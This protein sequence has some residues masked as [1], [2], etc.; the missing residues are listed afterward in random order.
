ML[1]ILGSFSLVIALLGFVPGETATAVPP[2]TRTVSVTG[3]GES[4]YP[5]FSP[6]V[7][8]YGV[9][10]TAEASP[11][12]GR[13]TVRATTSDPTGTVLVNGRPSTGGGVTVTGLSAG[14]EISVII[15]DS[16]GTEVHALVYLPAGFPHLTTVVDQPGTAAGDVMLTLSKWVSPAPSYEVAVDRNGVPAFVEVLDA[17]SLDLKPAPGGH[18]S[19]GRLTTA[20][21][22]TGQQIIELDERFQ[23]VRTLQTSGLVNTDAHD[24][25]LKPDGGA[26]LTAYEANAATGLTDAVIQELEPDGDVA[27]T[28]NSADHMDP[29]T[30]TTNVPGRA[31]Y[32]H[33]NSIQLLAD[34]DILASFRHTSSVLKIAWSAHDGFRRGDVV[35]RL[36]GRMSDFQ[37]L[38]D[39]YPACC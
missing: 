19:V 10:T 5:A 31:D 25:I 9:L 23:P 14:D 21:G 4:M 28:W 16:G 11:G 22:R 8:R 39:P 7:E 34:G 1:R 3:S 2:P 27:Y 24:A 18:Y 38:A 12:Q 6:A 30:E 13:V 29:E 36:G 33:I 32:A 26:I 17:A 37:F 35:W 20:P 15:T